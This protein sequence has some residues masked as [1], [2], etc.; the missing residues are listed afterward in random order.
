[1]RTVGHCR[2]S[3]GELSGSPCAAFPTRRIT[4]KP[5]GSGFYKGRR[6]TARAADELR[7][8]EGSRPV[9]SLKWRLWRVVPKR[10][11]SPLSLMRPGD[12]T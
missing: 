5:G 3:Q 8:A 7:A 9:K 10:L 1:M 11:L 4:R 6:A 2:L 12:S